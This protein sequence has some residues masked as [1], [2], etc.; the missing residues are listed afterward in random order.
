MLKTLAVAP[1]TSCLV[2]LEP[3]DK[4]CLCALADDTYS[5]L[6]ASS[7]NLLCDVW[8]TFDKL[9]SFVPFVFVVK[10]DPS[11]S[12]HYYYLTVV[13]ILI[14][15]LGLTELGLTIHPLNKN[16]NL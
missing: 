5:R 11:K 15:V 8:F 1:F 9:E 14:L 6:F 10:E 7:G 2:K 3:Q 12:R 16:L 13:L 4:I